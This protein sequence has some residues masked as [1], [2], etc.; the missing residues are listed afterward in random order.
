MDSIQ[1]TIAFPIQHYF[2]SS[3]KILTKPDQYLK[4]KFE[5]YQEIKNKV[6]KLKHKGWESKKIRDEV[7]GQEDMITY[8]SQGEFS[9]LNLVKAFMR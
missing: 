3:G 6:L 7:L 5:Y 4:L 1:K 2:C 8:I 9:K